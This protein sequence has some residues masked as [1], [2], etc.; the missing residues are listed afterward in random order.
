MMIRTSVLGG[1]TAALLVAFSYSVVADVRADEKSKVAFAG[2]LGRM[3][4][5]FGGRAA[6]EGVTTSRVV[7]GDRMASTTDNVEQIVDLTEEKIYDVDLKK[8]TY[9]VTTFDELRRQMED[10][11]KRAQEQAA[12]QPDAEKPEPDVDRKEM[13]VDFDVKDTGQRKPLNGFNTHEAVVTITLREK[14]KTLEDGGG[15]VLTADMWLA[16]TV[17]ALK[18]IADFQLRFARKLAGPVVA[19]ASAQQM[20]TALAMYPLMKDALARMSEESGKLD[21]TAIQTVTTID[22]VKSAAQMAEA[23]SSQPDDQSSGSVGGLLGGLARRAARRNQEPPSARSTVMTTTTEVLKVA[24]S[25]ADAELA[26][27]Q[28]FKEGR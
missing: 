13:E 26:I 1:A 25:V 18:E 7:K 19:G 20:S 28:G 5:L 4:N 12:K 22:A 23:Q 9:T 27:P 10:A 24:T 17:P 3:V 15:L 14:G 11:M 16:P 6:R 8:K 21:G 2:A